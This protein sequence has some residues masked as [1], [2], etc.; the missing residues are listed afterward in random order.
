M[1]KLSKGDIKSIPIIQSIADTTWRVAYK[2]II[3]PDQMDYM[4]EMMYS[5]N[6]LAYQIEQ[7]GHIFYLAQG[8]NQVVGFVSFQYDY[9]PQTTKIHK[10][11]ILPSAQGKG[12]GKA[13]IDCALMLSKNN[14]AKKIKLHVNRDNKAVQFYDHLGFIITQSLDVPIGNGYFMYDYIMEKELL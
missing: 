1:I 9:E 8:D 7:L 6:A 3:P 5:T 13:L 10:I 14:K 2:D 4:L 12:V 11:Y